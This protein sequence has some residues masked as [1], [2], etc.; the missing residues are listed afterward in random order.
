MSQIT[1]EVE[2]GRTRK[3]STS[4]VR[5]FFRKNSN[6]SEVKIDRIVNELFNILSV[7]FTSGRYP[8]VDEIASIVERILDDNV[9]NIS[10]VPSIVAAFETFLEN[11]PEKKEEKKMGKFTENALKVLRARYLLKDEKGNV[12]ETPEQ[13][14]RRVA[15][16]IASAEKK[17]D[18][19]ADVKKW[20]DIFYE[21]MYNLDFLPN[22]PTLMNAGTGIG[23]LSACFVLPVEDSIEGIFDAL[24]ATAI[25]HKTGGG[26]IA[27][28]SKVYTTFCGAENIEN[29][30]ESL[31]SSG[32]E[33]VLV[34]N[35]R[36]I[37]VSHLQIETLS[38]NKDT[39]IFER[40]RITKIW[41]YTLPRER[42]YSIYLEGGVEL[43]TSDWHPFMVF[44]NGEIK[45]KRADEL[46]IGDL[47]VGPNESILDS[48]L[49]TE[50]RYNVSDELAYIIGYFLGDGSLGRY[51][52]KLRLRFF[53]S[54]EEFLSEITNVLEKLTGVSY[55]ICKDHRSKNNYYIT[56]YNQKLIEQ[57]KTLTGL[58]PAEKSKLI[59]IPKFIWKSPK[60]IVFS[61]I[62][63]L[64]DSDGYVDKIK[65]KITYATASKDFAYDLATLFSLLGFRT[66][67][68]SRKPRKSHWSD[69]Y[70]I[71]IEGAG[72]L[73]RFYKLIGN[74]M[75]NHERRKRIEK[76]MIREHSSRSA[77]IDFSVVEE[78]LNEAGIKTKTTLIHR[79]SIVIGDKKFWLGRWKETGKVNLVKVLALIDELLKLNLSED[80]IEKLKKL[81]LVLPSL[82]KVKQI[83]RGKE[84][85]EFYDFTVEK[86]NNY[87]AGIGGLAV[88]HNT[89]FSFS[90]LRPKDDVVR[91]TGGIA[92]GPVSFMRIF[93]VA[94]DVIKQGGRRRGANMGILHASHPDIFEFITAK[95]E[96]GILQ[97]FNISV[98]VDE[99]FMKAVREN[100]EYP[101]IN[102]RNRKVVKKINAREL[103][104]KIAEMAWAT[105]DPGVIFLD[106]INKYNPVPHIGKIESTNP[107]VTGDTLVTT[108]KGLIPIKELTE[109]NPRTLDIPIL[110]DL[111][112]IG[113][114]GYSKVNPLKY[115]FTGVKPVYSLETKEGYSITAT[116]DHKFL[117][118]DGW[119]QLSELKEGDLVYIQS[120]GIFSDTSELPI[121]DEIPALNTLTNRKTLT[122]P[123]EWSDELGFVIG[124]LIGDGWLREDRVGFT[125]S[126]K[127][128]Y[129]LNKVR[130][131]ISEWYGDV[132]PVKRENDVYHLSYH[133]K[134][135]VE[136][137]KKL[138]VK[139]VR[140]SEKEVPWSIFRAPEKAVIGFLRGLFTADGSV[141]GTAEKGVSIRL[142]S[143]SIKLLKGVQLLLLNMGIKAKL[144]K[145]TKKHQKEFVY[146]TVNGVEKRYKGSTFYE[147]IISRN[148]KD[149]FIEKIGFESKEKMNKFS[150]IA[151]SK[152]YKDK[153][154]VR[155]KQITF[156]GEQ[157]VYDLIEPLTHS[158]IANG[159]IIHNCGEQPLL[160]YESCNLG[161]INLK[162]M[163]KG[164]WLNG[165]AEIDWEK[166]AKVTRLATHFLDNVIDVNNFPLKEIKKM[167]EKNR[168]IGLGLMGFADLLIMLGIPYDS[169]EAEALATAIMEFVNYHSK[170]ESVELAK[171]RG[172]FPA[173][174]G[175]IYEKGKLPFEGV[176]PEY[177]DKVKSKKF[178]E[179]IKKRP[180]VDWEGLKEEIKK[181][182]IRNSTTTTIA[183]TGTI[184]IIAGASS[185][186]EPIF[187]L[188]YERHVTVGRLVEVHQ[189]FEEIA[190]H[191]GF[192]SEELME[193]VLSQGGVQGLSEV[194]EHIKR[195]FVT[196]YDIAP[197]WHVRIQAAFQKFTDNA[198]SKTINMPASATVD[199]VKNA[200]LLAYDL[201]CKGIT[202][203]RDRSKD[204]QVLVRGLKKSET[205]KMSPEK[206][207]ATSVKLG[208][209][210]SVS[211]SQDYTRRAKPRPR[212]EVTFGRTYKVKTSCG[213]LYVTINEDEYG[214]FEVFARLGKTGGCLASYTEAIGRLI[215]LALRTGVDPNEV[216]EQLVGIRCPLP[217]LIGKHRVLS[218]ADAIGQAIKKYLDTRNE[219]SPFMK[220]KIAVSKEKK[221]EQPKESVT[222]KIGF[223]FVPLNPDN[224]MAKMPKVLH[225]EELGAS[226]KYAGWSPQCPECGGILEFQE[227]CAICRNCGYSKCL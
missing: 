78:I 101:L 84:V 157:P 15:K 186:I 29:I 75:K 3:I 144:Y 146:T 126:E 87:L 217:I 197:E 145:R 11:P 149:R 27:K 208:T 83:E 20:E 165:K 88:I 37:D 122:L 115:M 66:G 59:K 41:K 69:I 62:A 91:S 38:F 95:A 182:G 82:K 60:E 31:V 100:K 214:L 179:I 167:T 17:Y 142:A 111:K 93:D 45:E 193:K 113:E 168:K 102:P 77:Y 224:G 174:K 151:P 114:E 43:T 30:Y 79:K 12:I 61:F 194:P 132:K 4:D 196:A 39:G 8:R 107:C 220:Q 53:D 207:A 219:F 203:Y 23:Q 176:P 199:D 44:E 108:S 54:S 97:N 200:Y 80:S 96:Q 198:V 112:T 138:G 155:V 51:K 227:G 128:M 90:R 127:D 5:E 120:G 40:D 211:T 81:K 21:L 35:G 180:P 49:F 70:E 169:E 89:G 202:I 183:P 103:F 206:P 175:S 74:K 33:E 52:D 133:A 16:F 73:Y 204:V 163:V 185:G 85:T 190:K 166:L 141:Q 76:H 10:S 189:L 178:K 134:G 34:A 99:K 150:E 191:E 94:T 64:I 109:N 215:S 131:I 216:V 24:K 119:K 106:T 153:F 130:N 210:E 184:S 164:D 42:V 147:L 46:K 18:P 32:A 28:G 63:G 110:V 139:P 188:A 225:S 162:H 6:L 121:K 9:S 124:M 158:F 7:R 159:F 129:L 104:N 222:P 156:K 1:V 50:N 209:T 226:D 195:I 212:P 47:I 181:H 56:V 2:R 48:Y 105:G 98:S 201:G 143:T 25:I 154:V 137:F 171:K 218:C 170:L 58:D 192:Y 67:I 116:G 223:S 72:Q 161:S 135:F 125:F 173:F 65:P 172:A 86:N 117:T 152:S 55:S 123:T 22:S 57:I 187:A 136:F 160:P 19:S 213:N 71:S 118:P 148:S 140:A 14:F 177:Y 92:S 221:A 26:C 205:Q 13:M 68:R 36:Y